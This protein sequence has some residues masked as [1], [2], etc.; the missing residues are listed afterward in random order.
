MLQAHAPTPEM[1]GDLVNSVA[2]TFVQFYGDLSTNTVNESIRLLTEQEAKAG[3]E[4][5]RAKVAVQKYKADH[6]IA[7]LNEQLSGALNRLT[8]IESG[9]WSNEFTRTFILPFSPRSNPATSCR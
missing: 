9:S 7:S 6:R 3:K 1:A 8:G 5:E 4:V 2:S